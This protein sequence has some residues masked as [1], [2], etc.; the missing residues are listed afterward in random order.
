MRFAS[1]VTVTGAVLAVT[2][3]LAGAA[4]TSGTVTGATDASF[5]YEVTAGDNSVLVVFASKRNTGLDDA[6]QP[7]KPAVTFTGSD[8]VEQA[9][10]EAVF[11]RQPEAGFAA[12][13]GIYYLVNP[14]VGSG[15]VDVAWTD[16][17]GAINGA[18]MLYGVHQNNPIGRTASVG[19]LDT[20]SPAEVSLTVDD[21]ATGSMLLSGITG[22]YNTGA[23]PQAVSNVT[24]YFALAGGNSSGGG[25]YTEVDES[26][27]TVTW[28]YSWQYGGRASM[29]AAEFVEVPE[30]ATMSL[31][32]L[33]GLVALRRR[34]R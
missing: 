32:G 19:D 10:D 26:S 25:G 28:N 22:N 30:P 3:G 1:I 2:C 7:I 20:P 4:I 23:A 29:V 31:L 17:E 11:N 15:T 12:S 9:L 5:D 14:A 33:G 21:L 27:E 24:E 6:D 8:A 34:R 18:V 16:G 13:M